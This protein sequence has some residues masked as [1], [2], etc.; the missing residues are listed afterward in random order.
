M[1]VCVCVYVSSD[2]ADIDALQLFQHCTVCRH[3]LDINRRDS[4]FKHSLLN[5]LLCK[6]DKF[7]LHLFS[8]DIRVFHLCYCFLL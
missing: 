8:V 2:A 4:V 5:V 7:L 6:V 1:S 3:K